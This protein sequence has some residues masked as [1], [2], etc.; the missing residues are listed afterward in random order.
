[1]MISNWIPNENGSLIASS[2]LSIFLGVLFSVIRQDKTF[3]QITSISF[4]LAAVYFPW[5][6][7]G[8][9]PRAFWS[10]TFLTYFIRLLQ[11]HAD[12]SCASWSLRM[13]L[14]HTVWLFDHRIAVSVQRAFSG[15]LL[16][17]WVSHLF[18]AIA[19]LLAHSLIPANHFL[20]HSL[21]GCIGF[22]FILSAL[23]TFVQF[24]GLLINGYQYTIPLMRHPHKSTSL[25]E[26]CF[27]FF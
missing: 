17:H 22:F 26:V 19:V 12:P 11:M 25:R 6:M 10:I 23:D 21:A 4:G 15:T 24:W 18:L 27:F 20:I 5:K 8:A 13:R 7:V 1:M 2:F 16:F 3:R 9:F 14:S